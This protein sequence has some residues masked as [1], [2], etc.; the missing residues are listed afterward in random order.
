MSDLTHPD[1]SILGNTNESISTTRGFRC[2][3]FTLN[4][5]ASTDLAHISMCFDKLKGKYYI[6]QE[7]G[8]EKETPHYQ[9]F[10]QFKNQIKFSTLKNINPR[11]SWRK[12]IADEGF[13][14]IYCSKENLL[15][16]TLN[17]K[18]STDILNALKE[19]VLVTEYQNVV[20]KPWQQNILNLLATTPDSRTINWFWEPTGNVGKSFLMKYIASSQN[21][22]ICDG[23]KSD[24]FNQVL[25]FIQT[26]E[27][28]PTII[29]LDIP[30]TN[31]EYV[32]YGVIEQLKNGCIYSGKYEGGQCIFPHPHI[33][34][35]SNFEPD[36]FS[37]SSDRWNI[38]RL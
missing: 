16:D 23:K 21:V 5:Y 9:G 14:Y 3:C 11:I 25:T 6:G 2:W 37:M 33:V 28:P 38:I 19:N 24:I 26:Y 20:W 15:V 22:I 34:I 8:D 7:I 30:R 36:L 10:V 17:K 18:S 31:E 27:K 1:S 13:N 35:F 32:N 12:A 4:N 29:L